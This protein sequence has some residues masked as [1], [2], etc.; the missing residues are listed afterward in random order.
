[1]AID[2][3]EDQTPASLSN[4]IGIKNIQSRGEKILGKHWDIHWNT[5]YDSSR[6]SPSEIAT[7]GIGG[8]VLAFNNGNG[9]NSRLTLT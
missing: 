3:F 2:F 8:G 6:S 9:I 5:Y 1:L 4:N 7:L